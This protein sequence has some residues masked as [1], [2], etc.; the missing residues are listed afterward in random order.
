MQ[1]EAFSGIPQTSTVQACCASKGRA[2]RGATLASQQASLTC[3]SA[4]TLNTVNLL[5]G[6]VSGAGAS[7]HNLCRKPCQMADRE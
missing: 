4:Q 7:K 2:C 6:Y 3:R 1:R 5:K